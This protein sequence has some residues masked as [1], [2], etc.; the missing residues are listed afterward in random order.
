MAELPL[1]DGV[2]VDHVT[3]HNVV[4]R[5]GTD[6]EECDRRDSKADEVIRSYDELL[7][8]RILPTQDAVAERRHGKDGDACEPKGHAGRD[9]VAHGAVRRIEHAVLD[10]V[11]IVALVRDGIV[12]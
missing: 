9:V 10:T 1:V 8:R 5:S 12:A 4:E 11:W 3:A 7:A 2:A 6:V